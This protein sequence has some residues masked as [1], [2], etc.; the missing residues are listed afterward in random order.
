MSS[1]DRLKAAV[2]DA[3]ANKIGIDVDVHVVTKGAYD[4]STRSYPNSTTTIVRSKM[5]PPFNAE[6]ASTGGVVRTRARSVFAADVAIS[7][8]CKIVVVGTTDE[9]IVVDKVEH[10]VPTGLV[11]IEVSIEKVA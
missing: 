2:A 3:L 1:F 6:S 10:R 11:A 7:V 5:A 9:W 4:T 8:G